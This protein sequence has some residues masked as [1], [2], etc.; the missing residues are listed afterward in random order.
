MEQ[1]GLYDDWTY[2]WIF[3]VDNVKSLEKLVTPTL[4]RPGNVLIVKEG[5]ASY[6]SWMAFNAHMCSMSLN[7][8]VGV[9]FVHYT[10]IIDW[11]VCQAWVDIFWE[12]PPC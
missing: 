7:V 5:E 4:P 1:F 12:S 2:M 9:A 10:P 11:R 3:P 8:A 6:W